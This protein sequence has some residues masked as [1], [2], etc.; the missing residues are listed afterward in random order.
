MNLLQNK[1]IINT[2]PK[3]RIRPVGT[4]R[5][6]LHKQNSLG[7]HSMTF[8]RN[9]QNEANTTQYT[10]Q[11]MINSESLQS[12]I[13]QGKM[14]FNGFAKLKNVV[15]RIRKVQIFKGIKEEA[16][17]DSSE[18]GDHEWEE[19]QVE[20]D[21][22][23]E[24]DFYQ[25][26]KAME[27]DNND[28]RT[29]IKK[30]SQSFENKRKFLKPVKNI[31]RTNSE[32][33]FNK[34]IIE[35]KKHKDKLEENLRKY[36]EEQKQK[37]YIYQKEKEAFFEEQLNKKKKKLVKD[38]NS[39][40]KKKRE[41]LL[42][43]KIKD[44]EKQLRNLKGEN[45]KEKKKSSTFVKKKKTLDNFKNRINELELENKKILKKY[46]DI[47]NQFDGNE[48]LQDLLRYKKKMK[49]LQEQIE[50]GKK[51]LKKKNKSVRI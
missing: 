11:T 25:K 37:D 36:K 45:K 14:G 50:E 9:Y 13:V 22:K 48:L 31:D 17:N 6:R 12:S 27:K 18:N 30:K 10:V 26:I 16:Y 39:K 32:K 47:K 28:L 5:K 19:K 40:V 43:E 38:L 1:Q 15:N 46:Y 51:K 41:K 8:D 7:N 44:M 3:N 29:E 42:K 33:N 2:T 49:S 4:P 23:F 20:S 21:E 24:P 35:L 34:E